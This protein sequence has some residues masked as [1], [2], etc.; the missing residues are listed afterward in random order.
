MIRELEH[1]LCEERLRDL[2]L[3]SWKWLREDLITVY[4]YLK[5]G[6]QVNGGTLFSGKKQ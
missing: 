5:H 2:G 4:K 1:L 6:S 3:F